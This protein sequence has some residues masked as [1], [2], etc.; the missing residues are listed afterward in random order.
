MKRSTRNHGANS[1]TI[2]PGSQSGGMRLP[3]GTGRRKAFTVQRVATANQMKKI[4]EI[5][6]VGQPITGS[7]YK[8][9][10]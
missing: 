8:A 6:G 10:P 1:E 9:A 7:R 5:T 3:G 4:A 2:I